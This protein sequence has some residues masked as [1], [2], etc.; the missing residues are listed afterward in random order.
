MKSETDRPP[1]LLEVSIH[2]AMLSIWA[3]MSVTMLACCLPLAIVSM[4]PDESD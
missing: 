4:L 2:A 3:F 1:V